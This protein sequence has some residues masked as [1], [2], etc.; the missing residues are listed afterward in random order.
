[1]ADKIATLENEYANKLK[2]LSN[3]Y[4]EE[5]TRLKTE[6]SRELEEYNY[7]IKREREINTNAWL[8]EKKQREIALEQKELEI[9]KMI[10]DAKNNEQYL[11]DLENQVALFPELLEKEYAKGKKDATTEI[12]KENKYQTELL[13]KDFGSTID[14][15]NDKIIALEN[16]VKKY[17]EA[18]NILQEKLDKAY[19]E[20]KDMATKTVQAS[21]NVKI[22]STKEG[23]D[24]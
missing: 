7:I 20:I 1:M 24:N 19:L 5:E 18:N 4:K 13:K 10:E 3:T 22:I 12:E 21:S 17:T 16:E 6:R 11:K 14:R 23:S 15:Q 2:E 9:N 8:D